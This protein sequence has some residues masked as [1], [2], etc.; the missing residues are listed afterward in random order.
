[1]T[2]ASWPSV[3]TTSWSSAHPPLGPVSAPTFG[4]AL[5]PEHEP[6][7]V[8]CAHPPLGPVSAPASW[9]SVR[10]HRLVQRV[11]PPRDAAHAPAFGSSECTCL[12]VQRAHPPL[13]AARAPAL[14]QCAHHPRALLSCM[15]ARSSAGLSSAA[16]QSAAA[17]SA[18]ARGALL[19]GAAATELAATQPAVPARRQLLLVAAMPA[20]GSASRGQLRSA[21]CSAGGLASLLPAAVDE[22]RFWMRPMRRFAAFGLLWHC[23][24]C[25][26]L[27]GGAAAAAIWH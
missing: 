23:A 13:G 14:V 6:A 16:K 2:I 1:M 22:Y 4:H 10:T 3:S 5:A 26:R 24:V 15:L 9:S 19:R 25:G 27:R 11:H 21:G 20:G 12:L 17:R 7:L 18:V 8:Q